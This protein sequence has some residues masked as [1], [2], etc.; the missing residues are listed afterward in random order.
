MRILL[1]VSMCLLLM[2]CASL[3]E[4]TVNENGDYVPAE[5]GVETVFSFPE[6]GT[7]IIASDELVSAVLTAEI[8]DKEIP[9][10]K[11][12]TVDTYFGGNMIGVIVAKRWTTIF[13]LKT[14][15]FLGWDIDYAVESDR[16]FRY[17]LA[18]TLT[19]F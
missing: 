4:G 3:Q 18:F 11:S 13:E 1:V 12:V 6:I 15:I 5:A 17:G 8:I 19:K 16:R 14:G 10:V 7:G 9:L 2:G